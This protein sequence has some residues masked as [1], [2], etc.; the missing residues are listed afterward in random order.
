LVLDTAARERLCKLLGMLGSHHDGEVAAGGRKASEFLRAMPEAT[1]SAQPQMPAWGQML[2]ARL[3]AQAALNIKEVE[4]L[5][6]ML[7]W[8]GNPTPKQM[9]WLIDLYEALS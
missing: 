5:H 8:R 1:A 9:R 7:T 2:H 4:F 3:A 6:S